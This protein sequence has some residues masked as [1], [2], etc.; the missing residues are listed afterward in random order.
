MNALRV[1]GGPKTGRHPGDH[2]EPA[3]FAFLFQFERRFRLGFV[4]NHTGECVA[5]SGEGHA[6]ALGPSTAAVLVVVAVVR[7][8]QDE[9]TTP[10]TMA[11]IA[12]AVSTSGRVKPARWRV[13]RRVLMLRTLADLPARGKGQTS[14]LSPGAGWWITSLGRASRRFSSN[15]SRASGSPWPRTTARGCCSIAYASRSSRK[16]CAVRSKFPFHSGAPVDRLSR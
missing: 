4:P 13:E 1:P 16:A 2:L 6:F 8:D 9:Y 11:K 12:R 3:E 7:A 15:Q 10:I 14:M 5:D